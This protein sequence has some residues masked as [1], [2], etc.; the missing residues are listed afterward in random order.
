MAQSMSEKPLGG[1]VF[2][3]RP[4]PIRHGSD[5]SH[6]VLSVSARNAEYL[7]HRPFR[8]CIGDKGY[9]PRD[10]GRPFMSLTHSGML[11]PSATT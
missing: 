11:C 3:L 4:P 7:C 5:T 2:R 9:Q 8:Y 1:P 6:C 10:A